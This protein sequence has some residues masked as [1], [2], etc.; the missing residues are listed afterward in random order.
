MTKEIVLVDYGAIFAISWF[1][2]RPQGAPEQGSIQEAADKA[3]LW[4]SDL[5]KSGNMVVCFDSPPY[6]RTELFPDYKQGRDKPDG[7]IECHQ[8]VT[9]RAKKAFR[10]AAYP[11]A[12]SDDV[13]ASLVRR[14]R[15][16][17]IRIV[18]MDKDLLPLVDEGAGV[19]I[20][21]CRENGLYY[22]TKQSVT[23]KMQVPAHLFVHYLA[24]RGDAADAIPGG[25]GIGHVAAKKLVETFGSVEDI[26]RAADQ[27]SSGMEAPLRKKVQESRQNIALSASLVALVDNLDVPVRIGEGEGEA[28]VPV[29]QDEPV[30]GP[31]PAA[32]PAKVTEKL[33][34]V[35]EDQFFKRDRT[36]GIY[37]RMHAVMEDVGRIQKNKKASAGGNREYAYAGHNELTD[38]LRVAY[39]RHGI[40]RTCSVISS[41][42]FGAHHEHLKVMVEVRWT[43][44]DNRDDFVNV[45]QDAIA[46]CSA[47]DPKP[48]S[49]LSGIAMS[50]AQKTAEFKAFCIVGDDTPDAEK[51]DS[52]QHERR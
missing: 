5:D 10:W 18:T 28:H 45:Q 26:L 2:V 16:V 12:E 40:V 29:G 41:E 48:A 47:K 46:A 34:E 39:I 33:E 38:L 17:P 30:A 13:I 14:Y 8:A 24:L 19:Y 36:L 22:R 6:S 23:D 27:E 44:V 31:P 15:G 7:F 32:D 51:H 3:M 4:L 21:N 50:Y 35:L 52:K 25:K 11:G 9:A 43:S 20:Q 1:S 42:T 49:T 37:A